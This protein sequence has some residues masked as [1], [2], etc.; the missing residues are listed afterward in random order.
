MRNATASAQE[1]PGGREGEVLDPGA[2]PEVVGV[3]AMEKASLL[4]FAAGDHLVFEK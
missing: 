1:H 4:V 3:L 2:A